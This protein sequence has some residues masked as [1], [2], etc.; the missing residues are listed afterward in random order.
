M[1]G[2]ELPDFLGKLKEKE[3]KASETPSA[4]PESDIEFGPAK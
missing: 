2:V 3:K 1:A 4:A